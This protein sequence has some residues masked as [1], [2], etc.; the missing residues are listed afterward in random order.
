M[1]ETRIDDTLCTLLERMLDSATGYEEAAAA[2]LGRFAQTF[3]ERAEQRRAFVGEIKKVLHAH[4]IDCGA[5]Y[6]LLG[7][8]ARRYAMIK[9]R[10]D[11]DEEAVRDE[12]IECEEWLLEA[13]DPAL[14][15]VDAE[16]KAT[17]DDHVRTVRRVI[18][19]T[20][21]RSSALD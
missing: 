16:A 18:D 19:V 20:K 3:R 9:T 8:A 14:T 2:D 1:A 5:E 15:V 4:S 13:Y 12:L 10:L 21:I 6:L 7:Q 17:F 11:Y